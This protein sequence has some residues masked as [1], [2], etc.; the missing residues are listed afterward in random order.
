MKSQ[1]MVRNIFRSVFLTVF[2]ISIFAL[3]GCS[4]T[5]KTVP[6][7]ERIPLVSDSIQ[8]GEQML[9]D[10]KITYAYRLYQKKSDLSGLLE[11][12]GNAQWEHTISYLS[13]WINFLDSEGKI[14]ERKSLIR[15]SDYDYGVTGGKFQ[16][17]LEAPAGTAGISFEAN[18][19]SSDDYVPSHANY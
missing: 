6:V 13:V 8:K 15:I 2:A 18:P 11:I 17:Q 9:K 1:W 4:V 10:F 3:F 12:E 7:E 19:A 14:L 5:V 16:E